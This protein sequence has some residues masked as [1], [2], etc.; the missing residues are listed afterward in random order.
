[1]GHTP[2]MSPTVGHRPQVEFWKSQ[3]FYGVDLS[4]LAAQV[5]VSGASGRAERERE[6]IWWG[7]QSA[8]IS[9][10]LLGRR[11]GSGRV[12]REWMPAIGPTKYIWGGG[13]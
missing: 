6:L 7:G 5:G 2:G 10:W 11:R 9:G 13:I 1:M 12:V 3:N 8:S 4:F